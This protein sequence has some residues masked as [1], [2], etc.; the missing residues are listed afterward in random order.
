V[1]SLQVGYQLYINT[2]KVYLQERVWQQP[3]FNQAG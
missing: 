1:G 2:V 3:N